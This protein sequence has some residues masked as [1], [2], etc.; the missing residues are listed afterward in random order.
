MAK[1]SKVLSKYPA[2]ETCGAVV[3]YLSLP[4]EAEDTLQE[5]VQLQAEQ[6][7]PF[8]EGDYSVAY[9][10]LSKH[11][12]T[13][14][15][16]VVISSHEA[17][18][19][20]WYEWM[21]ERGLLAQKR[22]DLTAFGWARAILERCPKL[23]EGEHLVLLRAPTEQLLLLLVRGMLVA[24]R[25]LPAEATDA[26]L[27]HEGTVLLSQAAMGGYGEELCSA[28][29]F[30]DAPEKAQPLELLFGD[31]VQFELLA[32]KDA[33]ALLQRGL[34]LRDEAKTSFDLTPQPWR[35][36]A[37]ANRQK[38]MMMM[39]AVVLGILWVACAALLYLKPLMAERRVAQLQET[40][41]AQQPAYLEAIGLNSRVQLIERY[42]DRKYSVL[43]ILRLICMAKPAAMTFDSFVYSQPESRQL[44]EDG[45][46][47]SETLRVQGTT[48]SASDVYAFTDALREDPMGRIQDVKTNKLRQDSATQAQTFTVEMFFEKQ[49]VAQ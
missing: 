49:E 37:K 30:A 39:G 40:L 7:S 35:D 14:E 46:K 45:Q 27:I 11:D 44:L 31:E 26:D 12:G 47:R 41:V 17:L 25:A 33:D 18:N 20:S 32:E 21:K 42:H 6:I 36:E 24:L 28:V 34:K 38:Q 43:E 9:E 23:A 5:A 22:L 2:V 29:C 1:K 16:L 10:P 13:L 19:A 48:R 3:T 4:V 15:G 8:D